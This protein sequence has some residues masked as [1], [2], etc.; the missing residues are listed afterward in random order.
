MHPSGAC[1]VRM[2]LRCILMTRFVFCS[3]LSARTILTRSHVCAGVSVRLFFFF[4]SQRTLRSFFFRDLASLRSLRFGCMCVREFL[5][6]SALYASLRGSLNHPS[7][8]VRFAPKNNVLSKIRRISSFWEH[9]VFAGCKK[10]F[11][12]KSETLRIEI[13]MHRTLWP[14]YLGQIAD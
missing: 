7:G 14:I 13:V 9:R 10:L 2:H 8:G 6:R 5:F 4:F 3:A 12:P 11:T 1:I